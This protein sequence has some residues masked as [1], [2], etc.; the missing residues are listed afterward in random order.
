ME[1]LEILQLVRDLVTIFGVLVGF[2]YYA[3]TVRAT[4]KS[5]K[6]EMF[7]QLY[8]TNVDSE[9]YRKFWDLM[10]TEWE[11]IEDYM[12]KYGPWTNP[13]E[14]A[15]RMSHWSIYDGL[16][17]LVKD[18]M[19]DVNMVYRVLGLRIIMMWHKFETII[20]GLRRMAVGSGPDYG[21][22][23]DFMEN[24]EWLASKMV[25]MRKLRGYRLPTQTLHPT[26]AQKQV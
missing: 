8:K 18:D 23:P 3:L 14:A 12:Q 1:I 4:R 10:A 9:G 17:I 7:M 19:V 25:K 16:G 13:N 26:N 5:K 15:E 24:F 22:G 21:P 11:D 20:N 2:T 6:T